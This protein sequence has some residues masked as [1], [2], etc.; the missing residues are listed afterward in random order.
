[1]FLWTKRIS[2]ETYQEQVNSSVAFQIF[3]FN[4]KFNIP[5]KRNFSDPNLTCWKLFQD[6]TA[7]EI[8]NFLH[9]IEYKMDV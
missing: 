8:T 7:R 9:M 2:P 6:S 4:K 5:E 1:M 3:I